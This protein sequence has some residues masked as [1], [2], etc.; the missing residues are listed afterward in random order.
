QEAHVR[1]AALEHARRCW[2][3]ADRA[4]LLVLEHLAHGLQHHVV[5][6]ALPQAIRHLLADHLKLIAPDILRRRIIEL[7]DFYRHA[8]VES[9]AA[10]HLVA[11]DRLTATASV[12][13]HLLLRRNNRDFA[14]DEVLAQAQLLRRG[15]NQPSLGLAPEQLL[16]EPIE[17]VLQLL[18]LPFERLVRLDQR[19][20]ISGS[21]FLYALIGRHVR[22][23]EIELHHAHRFSAKRLRRRT[24]S[25]SIPSSRS[26]KSM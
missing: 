20:D 15:L 13:L 19:G 21:E 11:I 17:L 12:A 16:L 6:G 22:I 4:A 7:D 14:G 18:A 10:R 9:Q 3:T 25:I 26:F 1:M 2:R 24:S 8:L 5:A 23:I